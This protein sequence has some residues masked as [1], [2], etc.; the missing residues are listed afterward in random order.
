VLGRMAHQ[1]RVTDMTHTGKTLN[2]NRVNIAVVGLGLASRIESK[3]FTLGFLGSGITISSL[4]FDVAAALKAS[5][6]TAPQL[7]LIKASSLHESSRAEIAEL[8]KKHQLQQV[9]V[10]YNYGNEHVIEAMR[11]SG[12][13]VR[14]EPISDDEL[15]DLICSVLLIDAAQSPSGLDM[16]SHI[17]A[18]K[19]SEKTLVRVAGIST[20]VLCECPKH[21]AELITQLASFEQYSQ[22]CLSKSTQDADLHAYLSAVSGSA[23]ALFERAL[24]RVAEHEGID[25]SDA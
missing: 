7:M 14:R 9:I 2:A 19:Y 13:V 4:F 23:R 8:I 1:T 5:F 6:T 12:I 17:P 22:E 18:R 20:S 25:L 10:I 3:K 21:V 24:E 16:P 15:S 11:I